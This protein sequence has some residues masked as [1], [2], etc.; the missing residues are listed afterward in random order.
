VHEIETT[1]AKGRGGEVEAASAA[2]AA[3]PSPLA[4]QAPNVRL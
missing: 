4:G 2:G 3:L 1:F